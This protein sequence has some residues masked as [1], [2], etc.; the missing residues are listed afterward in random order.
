MKFLTFH[1]RA[2][3]EYFLIKDKSPNAIFRMKRLPFK[4]LNRVTDQI[5]LSQRESCLLLIG[6]NVLF[7]ICLNHMRL[8]SCVSREGSNATAAQQNRSV[9]G[10][11]LKSRVSFLTAPSS[12]RLT[13]SRKRSTDLRGKLEDVLL[14]G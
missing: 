3:Q 7:C 1:L 14:Q 10:R 13:T 5:R 9:S 2:H 11:A 4:P 12:E 6:T 8:T